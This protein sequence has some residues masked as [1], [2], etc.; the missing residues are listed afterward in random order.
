M[1]RP[2]YRLGRKAVRGII[3][4]TANMLDNPVIVLVYH[5]VTVLELD[6]Q[7]LAVSPGNFRSQM[8]VL[9]ESYPV[10]RFEED[11][12]GVNTP[13]VCI[14]FD[15]GYADNFL[16]ALPVLEELKIPATFFVSAGNINKNEE[17]WWD[18]LERIIICS[19]CLP[20]NF[21]LTD[22]ELGNEWPTRTAEEK[23]TFYREIHYLMK[24]G[25]P[26]RRTEW[27]KQLQD[28][29]GDGPEGRSTHRPLTVAELQDLARS[30][31]AT[32]GAH[33]VTHTPLSSL[34][35]E[36]QRK[37][38]TESKSMLENWLEREITVFSYPFGDRYD[39]TGETVALVREAGF[40]KAASNFP[41]Q[42]HRW[43]D[44]LQIPRH[45][46]RNWDNKTF[47]KYLQRFWHS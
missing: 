14:T 16:E 24:K 25:D 43:T 37:E 6:S 42:W 46:V 44:P 26:S 2:A 32:I 20:E 15:D 45:L 5:R 39:Y 31:M 12:M 28:W 29:A 9:K 40:T 27:I 41:G 1:I 36:D 17:F 21:T 11:W 19:R 10:L 3:N 35:T 7:L 23:Q 18:E 33:T 22:R 34:N 38:I 13:S 30:P 8:Q 4:R 47:R